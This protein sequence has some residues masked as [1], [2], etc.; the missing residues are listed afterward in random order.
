MSKPCPE[1]RN[2]VAAAPHGAV[3]D[4]G[5]RGRWRG[6]RKV[7][8]KRSRT[9]PEAIGRVTLRIAGIF[10]ETEARHRTGER[11]KQPNYAVGWPGERR[12]K[13]KLQPQVLRSV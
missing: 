8:G 11:S 6:G 7:K 10:A 4:E 2:A 5:R 9:V 1:I 13:R 3:D 12:G